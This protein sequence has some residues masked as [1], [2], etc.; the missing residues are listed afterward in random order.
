MKAE[1]KRRM[2]NASFVMLVTSFIL[3]QCMEPELTPSP[4][5]SSPALSAGG[6]NSLMA[7]SSECPKCTYMVPVEAT[8][9]DGALLNIK[10]GDVICLDAAL[11][12]GPLRFINLRG[13]A[14]N[15]ITITNCGGKVFMMETSD[16]P[17]AIKILDSRYFRVTGDDGTSGDNN[18]GIRMSGSQLGLSLDYLTTNFEVDHVEV[19]YVG[20][21]GIMAKTDPNCNDST[22]RGTFTTKDI[23]IHDNFV[24][25]TGGEGLYVGNSFYENGVEMSCGVR[26]PQSIEGVKIYNNKLQFTGRDGIQLG[27]AVSGANV[28]NNKIEYFGTT[29]EYAQNSGIQ[30][31][32]G[33][34][35]QCFNNLIKNGSGNG[36]TVLG[37][38]GNVIQSNVIINSGAA[39]IFSDDRYTPGPSFTFSD[40]IIL[41]P[42]GD[43]IRLYSEKIPMNYVTH[44]L[45][46]NPGNYWRYSED[47][48]GENEQGESNQD[49]DSQGQ[50][51]AGHTPKITADDA[52]VFRRSANVKLTESGNVFTSN[53]NTVRSAYVA[54]FQFDP[55]NKS[56]SHQPI[57]ITDLLNI[58]F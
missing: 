11:R 33:T 49:G 12:Y 30:I 16:A 56:L 52:Y 40:N 1:R 26:L 9:I 54:A 27:A 32:E 10:P 44:N 5:L 8:N 29:G 13:D 18:Y 21:A 45:I 39:G 28:F 50:S 58:S 55:I 37:L 3:L 25:Y 57:K 51:I 47:D 15:P 35:G 17:Y 2:R 14:E 6:I 24:H 48:Q 42:N 22:V 36:I 41:N 43:G 31:G 53:T 38:G 4:G 20:F 46:V 19:G 34:G 7:A 23:S